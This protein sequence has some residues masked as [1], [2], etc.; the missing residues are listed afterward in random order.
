[1]PTV[2][3]K[4]HLHKCVKQYIE[5]RKSKGLT[6]SA[7]AYKLGVSAST[8]EKIEVGKRIPSLPM[9]ERLCIAVGAKLGVVDF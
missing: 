5:L 7:V 4:D 2:V 3:S 8:V 9:M 6:Q 1:M